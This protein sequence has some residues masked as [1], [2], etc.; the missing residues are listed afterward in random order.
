[1]KYGDVVAEYR[2]KSIVIGK[3]VRMRRISGESFFAT[4]LDVTDSGALLVLR[5]DG[6][7]EELIS[8]EVSVILGN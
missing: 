1:M 6:V 4:V 5:E 8:A 2:E 7:R 3:R